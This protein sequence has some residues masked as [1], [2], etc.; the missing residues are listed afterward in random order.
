MPVASDDFEF[1]RSTGLI[2]ELVSE[3]L[4]VAEARVDPGVLN[5]Q[6][7]GASLVLEH[8]R[9]AF[10]SYPYEWSFAAL[11]AAALFHLDLQLRALG[12]GVAL[13][14]ASAYNVQFNGAK[15]IFID[16]LSFR[17]YRE[18]EF[19][20]GHRQF[21]EQFVNPLL[22]RSLLGVPHN[23]WYRGSLEG[24][25]A[26]ELSRILP[27]HTRLSWNTLTNVFV[28]AR[29][30]QAASSTDRALETS[31]TRQLPKIGFEQMLRGLRRWISRMQPKA[32][33]R[34]EWQD[35]AQDN[36]YSD[37]ED[38]KKRQCVTQF[39]QGYRPQ[40]LF[41]LG[42]NTGDYSAL[43]LTSGADRVIGFDFDHGAL[44]RAFERARREALNF[45]PL[46]L[47]A[48]NPSPE[49][50]WQQA[51]RQGLSRRAKGDAVLALALVHHLAISRNVPLDG[52]LDWIT[53]M[54]PRGIIEFVPKADPM[55]QQL[56]LLRQDLF[57]D[58]T[59]ENFEALLA[60]R[61]RIVDSHSVSSS[62]RTLYIYDRSEQD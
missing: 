41:D 24:I 42:C 35:Y 9:L 54:A 26:Q 61:G 12:K 19:W 55:V 37:E 5:G 51:E 33:S 36:S 1:V 50:G 60:A 58:Y 20:Y 56:L 3:Q 38:A 31:K 6:G 4:L 47:D 44:D 34:S 11:K 62:G 27:W 13:T 49:Q 16:S 25:S 40:L 52:V 23:A 43:A 45:L 10:V 14:D 48:V 17:R 46:H 29:L 59:R 32:D 21:C 7:K 30:Q 22:L 57:D 39:T 53:A 8:P 28:Q 2:D 15:P 18:G